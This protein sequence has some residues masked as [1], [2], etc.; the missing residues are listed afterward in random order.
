MS[1]E[2]GATLSHECDD[3]DDS[4]SCSRTPATHHSQLAIRPPAPT[5]IYS[6]PSPPPTIHTE[7][8]SYKPLSV[9]GKKGVRG[10]GHVAQG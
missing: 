5:L 2:D 7:T 4:K 1:T 9:I 3:D 10:E 6:L 8:N